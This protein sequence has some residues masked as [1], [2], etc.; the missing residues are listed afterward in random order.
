MRL[1]L[2]LAVAISVAAAIAAAT[3][4]VPQAGT[5]AGLLGRWDITVAPAGQGL[6]RYCWLE[7]TKEGGAVK[8][9]FNQGGGAVFPLPMVAIENGQL[10]FEH[11]VGRPAE[12]RKA[13][14]TARLNGERLEG[15]AVMGDAPPRAFTG[16][17]PPA[18]PA[19]APARKAGKPIELFNGK[20]LT[21]WLG[22]NPNR[23]LGWSV[24]DGVLVNEK[25]ANNI[26]TEQRFR[27][28]KLHVEFNVDPKSNSGVYLRGRYEIQVADGGGNPPNVH[29][30]GALYG[31]TTPPPNL[32]KAPGEWQTFDITLIANRLTVEMNGTRILD[33]EEVPGITGGALDAAEGEPG[34]IMLQGDHGR[35]QYRKVVLTPLT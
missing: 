21:G 35:I 22:Q 2:V 18:W 3:A 24:V 26:Y 10:K 4:A 17:R 31:F 5:D 7:V 30:Q 8:G 29:S 28:F 9:R 1:K 27:D 15:T 32:E 14:Y 19:K 13:V 6:A 11:P 25:G 12:N 23:A 20:D 34:P 33:N 16:I